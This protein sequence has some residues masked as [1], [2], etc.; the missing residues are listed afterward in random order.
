MGWSYCS[1]DFIVDDRNDEEEL[2]EVPFDSD[3]DSG[4]DGVAEPITQS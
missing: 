4:S 1:Y 3:S 2:V